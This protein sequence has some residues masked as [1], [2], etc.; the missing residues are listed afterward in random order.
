MGSEGKSGKSSKAR[1]ESGARTLDRDERALER[2]RA[3]RKFL[4]LALE[5]NE[6]CVWQA[7]ESSQDISESQDISLH[8]PSECRVYVYMLGV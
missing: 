5:A 3:P 7:E 8:R 1:E 2:L 6:S 4:G